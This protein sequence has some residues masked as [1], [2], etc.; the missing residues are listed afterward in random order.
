MKDF[1]YRRRIFR[2]N[3]ETPSR[4]I[5]HDNFLPSLTRAASNV[6]REYGWS[7]TPR[8]HVY[9]H[10]GW[11]RWR[12]RTRALRN[13]RLAFCRAASAFIKES[14]APSLSSASSSSPP[15]STPLASPPSFFPSSPPPPLSNEYRRS[16]FSFYLRAVRRRLSLLSPFIIFPVPLCL[17]LCLSFRTKN[18]TVS[19]GNFHALRCRERKT[20]FIYLLPIVSATLILKDFNFNPCSEVS[21]FFCLVYL[22]AILIVELNLSFVICLSL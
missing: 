19:A 6:G 22:I 11:D 8:I 15:R 12:K 1:K 13:T 2:H 7:E 21:Y 9:T 18:R 14:L 4:S 10:K 20:I 5:I 3:T 17:F 16:V